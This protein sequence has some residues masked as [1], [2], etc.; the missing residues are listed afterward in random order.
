[1][2]RIERSAAV[3]WEGSLARG[4]GRISAASSGA[5]SV[6][7][8][9]N[10]TRVGAPGP[11]TSPE[12]LLAA[13]HAACFANSLAAELSGLGTPPGRL[14]LSCL[15]IM[16]EVAGE[17]HRIVGSEVSVAAAVEA[18]DAEGLAHAVE[19]ADRSCPFSILLRAAG[20]RVEARSTL[21]DA[22]S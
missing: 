5:F 11:N 14:E 12:E 9:T 2:P 19:L 18:L 17:G 15:I 21:L 8:Y 16:D 22:G 13:A 20:A 4:G 3:V 1:V 7:P 6:L 10:A